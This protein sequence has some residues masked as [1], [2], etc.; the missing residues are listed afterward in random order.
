M[1]SLAVEKYGEA[2]FRGSGH[3]GPDDKATYTEENILRRVKHIC[4]IVKPAS[5]LDCGCATGFLV[6]GFMLL[7]PAI[8]VRG[9]DFSEYA[10]DHANVDVKHNLSVVDITNGL[11]YSDNEFD[12]V[13]AFDLLEHI[14]GYESLVY[15]VSEL[16][17]VS[18]RWILLRQPMV[19]F[20]G[21]QNNSD[22]HEWLKTLNPLPH[23]ARL[24]LC[25]HGSVAQPPFPDKYLWEHPNQHP[26]QFWIELFG[27]YG[28]EL[29]ELPE[30]IYHFPNV[31]MFCSFNLLVFKRGAY[32]V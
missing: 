5:V 20:V 26:R 27:H 4:D 30:W 18:G 14:H 29:I 7:D 12:L 8:K 3:V 1:A 15:A 28:Y 17:R 19:H 10:V 21:F 6:H 11:P 31:N 22:A 9:C 24:E 25:D 16:C 32:F 2:Y 23:K 13:T